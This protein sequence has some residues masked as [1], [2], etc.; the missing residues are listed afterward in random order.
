MVHARNKGANGEREVVKLLNGI[1]ER[2]LSSQEWDI[3]IIETARKCIQRNQ[4]QSAVGGSDLN[5][6]FGLAFEVKRCEQLHI[7]AWWKQTVDQ[8]IRNN[9]MPVLIYRQSH[10]P[11]R[12]IMNGSAI[13]PGK[14]TTAVR[15]E[16]EEKDFVVWFYSWV[17][18]KLMAN[19]LPRV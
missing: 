12:V 10:Q 6:V 18:Y 17:Y 13:L 9:E 8:A 2:V 4:N 14:R 5:G 11:W 1:I 16:I 19:E 7:E 3:G 15:M